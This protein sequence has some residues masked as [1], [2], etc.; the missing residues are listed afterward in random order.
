MSREG[1][2]DVDLP[3]PLPAYE[4]S[5]ASFL[6][7]KRSRGYDTP[8]SSD[9]AL[10]SSD[11]LPPSAENYAAKRRKKRYPGTWW[12]E[13][14]AQTPND[15][16]AGCL[17]RKKSF[18]RNFDSGIYMGSESSSF[19][20]E[21]DLDVHGDGTGYLS[22]LNQ[23]TAAVQQAAAAENLEDEIAHA[24]RDD[25][26][27]P[28]VDDCQDFFQIRAQQ[29]VQQCL[30]EGNETVDLSYVL[31]LNAIGASRWA[32]DIFQRPTSMRD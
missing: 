15:H 23:E 7:R 30:D 31:R 13:R 24:L 14:L 5:T 8:T 27:G 9:P 28:T 18:R 32:A 1:S 17:T 3:P 22:G 4:Q 26:L 29:A 20:L 19:G 10:F 2:P 25:D 21:N 12:G 16:E 11:D 6:G